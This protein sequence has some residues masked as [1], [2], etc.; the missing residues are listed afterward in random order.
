MEQQNQVVELLLI[1]KDHSLDQT[2]DQKKSCIGK[3]CDLLQDMENTSAW[4][5]DWIYKIMTSLHLQGEQMRGSI[6]HKEEE[7][8]VLAIGITR[9]LPQV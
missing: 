9:R 1:L 2:E 6:D 7:L 8:E 5:S 3:G 4:S